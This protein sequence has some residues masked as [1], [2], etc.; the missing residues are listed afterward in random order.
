[1]PV[2]CDCEGSS[3]QPARL[4]DR[5]SWHLRDVNQA[6]VDM[7]RALPGDVRAHMVERVENRHG[8]RQIT[9]MAG[10]GRQQQV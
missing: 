6:S 8:P 2:I 9:S 3:A 1:M 4:P 7:V 10:S 5:A